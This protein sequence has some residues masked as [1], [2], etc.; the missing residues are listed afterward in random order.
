[1]IKTAILT[2]V[3]ATAITNGATAAFDK[4][5][6]SALQVNSVY[7]VAGQILDTDM[8]NPAALDAANAKL[9]ATGEQLRPLADY[10]YGQ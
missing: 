1:M 5:Q 7:T 3:S 4:L 10:A 6:T 9:Y 2:I 8:T